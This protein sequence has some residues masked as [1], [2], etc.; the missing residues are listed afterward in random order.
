MPLI[1][2]SMLLFVFVG[3]AVEPKDSPLML[4]PIG[5]DAL[6]ASKNID[7]LILSLLIF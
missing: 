7:I 2:P 4:S 3:Y 5:A 1:M 6:V